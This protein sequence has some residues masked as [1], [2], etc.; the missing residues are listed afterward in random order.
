VVHT[1]VIYVLRGSIKFNY[2]RC[3]LVIKVFHR[4]QMQMFLFFWVFMQYM[5]VHT[6]NQSIHPSI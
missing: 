5:G 4:S 6:I 3:S 2:N 1:D